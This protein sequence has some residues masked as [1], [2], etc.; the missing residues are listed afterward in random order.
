MIPDADDEEYLAHE[1]GVLIRRRGARSFVERPLI[2]ASSRW[3]PDPWTPDRAGVERVLRRLLA[4]VELGQLVPRVQLERAGPTLGRHAHAAAWF[5]GIDEDRTA[6]FGCVDT[7]FPHPERLVAHR[8]H[9]VAH[10]WRRHHRMEVDDHE[11]E[12]QLTDLTTVYLGFG[13]FTANA[14]LEQGQF[15]DGVLRGTQWNRGGYLGMPHFAWLLAAQAVCRDLG[16]CDRRRLRGHLRQDQATLFTGWHRRLVVQRDELRWRLGLESE[17]A[18]P[19]I[20]LG[21]Q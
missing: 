17:Y 13:L 7:H 19:Q 8:C 14:A 3:F 9:E 16:W 20:P 10:A 21:G 2:E 15:D 1:L 11:E 4:Y 12:E 5:G 18:P 6:H